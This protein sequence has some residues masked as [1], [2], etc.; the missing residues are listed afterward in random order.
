M[1]TLFPFVITL[2]WFLK[3]TNKMPRREGFHNYTSRALV[4]KGIWMIFPLVGWSEVGELT[5]YVLCSR[6][7]G[8]PGLPLARG[9]PWMS[10]RWRVLVLIFFIHFYTIYNI[11]LIYKIF[12][13][14]GHCLPVARGSPWPSAPWRATNALGTKRRHK[15]HMERHHIMEMIWQIVYSDIVQWARFSKL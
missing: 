4:E 14:L 6:V 5:V 1:F 7:V 12:C 13:R 8:L 2:H 10:P 11:L 9:S 3:R 15:S